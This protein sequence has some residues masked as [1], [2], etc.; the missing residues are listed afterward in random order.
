MDGDLGLLLWG[1]RALLVIVTLG[2]LAVFFVVWRVL[3][4]PVA[5][6]ARRARAAGDGWAPFLRDARGE[7]G[8]LARNRWWATFRADEPG[9]SGALT[10]RWGWWTFTAV[11]VAAATAYAMWLWLRMLLSG[12][13]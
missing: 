10:W 13:G 2:L 8:P 7:W 5:S 1:V 11:V 4:I 3:V 9:T 12:W 6:E